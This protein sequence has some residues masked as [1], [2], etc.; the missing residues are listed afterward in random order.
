MNRLQTSRSRERGFALLLVLWTVALL[1]LLGTQFLR[2]SRIEVVLAHN[3]SEAASLQAATVTGAKVRAGAD[4]LLAAT[5]VSLIQADCERTAR[6]YRLIEC[7]TATACGAAARQSG[8]ARAYGRR[9]T[10][11]DCAAERLERPADD[12]T[13]RY[14][15]RDHAEVVAT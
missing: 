5:R 15:E 3:L 10:R 8:G 13:K 6:Y 12:Q 1:A 11:R 7:R 2:A 4:I 9:A 14:G